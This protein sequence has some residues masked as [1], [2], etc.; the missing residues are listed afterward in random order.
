MKQD[1][2]SKH[3]FRAMTRHREEEEIRTP[4]T[5]I[6]PANISHNSNKKRSFLR[7]NPHDS[8]TT[9]NM[10]KQHNRN[11][12][13]NTTNLATT[14]VTKSKNSNFQNLT[15]STDANNNNNNGLNQTQNTQQH[16]NAGFFNSNNNSNTT[17]MNTTNTTDEVIIRD[18]LGSAGITSYDYKTF[19]SNHP[20]RISKIRALEQ[21]EMTYRMFFQKFELDDD[22]D[23]EFYDNDGIIIQIPN[24]SREETR[25][26]VNGEFKTGFR[27]TNTNTNT[28]V[29]S[30]DKKL[31][32]MKNAFKPISKNGLALN[33]LQNS[34]LP[35]VFQNSSEF[36]KSLSL[37][38][39]EFLQILND[40][41]EQEM[42]DLSVEVVNESKRQNCLSVSNGVFTL[43]D[44][45][46]D[47]LYEPSAWRT[48]LGKVMS[49][50][51]RKR[52][53][54]DLLN[55]EI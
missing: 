36:L 11:V 55:D 3:I 51:V 19:S 5:P 34:K 41:F 30:L 20:L 15:S 52:I 33:K 46:F 1:G 22:L 50:D 25:K 23:G 29:E 8:S 13:S 18:N 27:T 39:L 24:L 45:P 53:K 28:K 12:L 48:D 40:E 16:Q 44:A 2:G 31:N 35:N 17:T 6:D 26:L 9:P 49:H 32:V 4:H 14:T 42:K 43:I 38:D 21:S 10:K 7:R 47:Q 37:E 54:N